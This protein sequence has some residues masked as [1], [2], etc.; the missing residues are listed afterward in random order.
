MRVLF[1]ND[2]FSIA[3]RSDPVQ[4]VL[5]GEIDISSIPT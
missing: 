5:A 3:R 2:A 4:L 1:A